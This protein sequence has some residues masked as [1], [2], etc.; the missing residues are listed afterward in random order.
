MNRRLLASHWPAYS[1]HKENICVFL[2]G[3]WCG[4][5]GVVSASVPAVGVTQPPAVNH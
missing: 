2:V 1:L 3:I 5:G 4:E